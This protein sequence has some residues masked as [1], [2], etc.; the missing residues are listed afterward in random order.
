MIWFTLSYMKGGAAELWANVYVDQALESDDW[1]TWEDCLDKLARDFGDR[2][3]P[4]KALEEMGRLQQGKKPIWILPTCD[5]P[6][7]SLLHL[8]FQNLHRAS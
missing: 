5:P 7:L 2:E 1:G 4:R 3:E 6:S 8:T